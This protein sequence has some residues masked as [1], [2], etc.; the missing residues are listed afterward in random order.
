[1]PSWTVTLRSWWIIPYL[2]IGVLLFLPLNY[3]AWRDVH[4]PDPFWRELHNFLHRE[5]AARYAAVQ[6]VAWPLAAWE[7]FR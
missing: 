5:R 6:I 4:K 7:Q 2:A 3:L 1:M